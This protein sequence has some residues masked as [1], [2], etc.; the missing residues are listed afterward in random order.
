MKCRGCE[1]DKPEDEFDLRKDKKIPTRRPYCVL[2]ARNIARARFDH[3]K[4]TAF[5]KLKTSRTR[6]RSQSIK[7]PFDLDADYLES[8]WTDTCPVLGVAM[9]KYHTQGNDHSAELDRTVPALGYVKGN[10][11][12]IS[13][14]ANRAKQDFSLAEMRAMVKWMETKEWK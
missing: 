12:F 11:S 6:S 7:V 8:I 5:F 2:C 1:V 9:E 14:R 10:V 3:H 4:R 13:R